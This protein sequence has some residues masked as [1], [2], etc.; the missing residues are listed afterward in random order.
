MIFIFLDLIL[1]SIPNFGTTLASLENNNYGIQIHGET[2]ERSSS[3]SSILKTVEDT[4]TGYEVVLNIR[5]TS[6]D[7]TH[8]GNS[9]VIK[10]K[11]T[12]KDPFNEEKDL[13][14]IDVLKNSISEF[15]ADEIEK[16]GKYQT[17]I[18]LKFANPSDIAE[19]RETTSITMKGDQYT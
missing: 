11:R 18:N 4:S 7:I 16:N 19:L 8:D 2:H 14:R 12:G 10:A 9:L 17:V 6:M 1:T 15:S 13:I 5:K 3:E